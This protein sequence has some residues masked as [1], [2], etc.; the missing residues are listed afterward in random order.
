MS[1]RASGGVG[2]RSRIQR[3][4]RISLSALSLLK[5]FLIVF[6]NHNLLRNY[7]HEMLTTIDKRLFAQLVLDSGANDAVL[8][9]IEQLKSI[10]DALEGHQR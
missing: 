4:Y 10:I 3:L 9:F 2:V 1:G 8:I 7:N 6:A 5:Q